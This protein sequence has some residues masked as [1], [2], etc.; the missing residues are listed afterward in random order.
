MAGAVTALLTETESFF[1][2]KRPKSDTL[3][4]KSAYKR[5]ELVMARRKGHEL[6]KRQV[7]RDVVERYY[8]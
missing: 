3:V 8:E 6:Y 2:A 5:Y 7:D 4:E 1:K